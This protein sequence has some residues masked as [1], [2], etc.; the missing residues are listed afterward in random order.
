M[1][2]VM[3]MEGDREAVMAIV[4]ANHNMVIVMANHNMAIVMAGMDITHNVATTMVKVMR[5]PVPL[6]QRIQDSC[7]RSQSFKD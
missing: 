7:N 3:D 1:E 2:V 6:S 4:M 5:N